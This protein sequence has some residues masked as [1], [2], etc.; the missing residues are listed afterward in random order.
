[1]GIEGLFLGDFHLSLWWESKAKGL[2]QKPL[3]ATVKPQE[4]SPA[5]LTDYEAHHHPLIIP[6]VLGFSTG[7]WHWGVGPLDAHD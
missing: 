6:F 3:A 5:L 2:T 7:G 1:M 4:K